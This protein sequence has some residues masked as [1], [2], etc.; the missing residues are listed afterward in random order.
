[1]FLNDSMKQK[2]IRELLR[3]SVGVASLCCLIA[4]PAFASEVTGSFGTGVSSGIEGTVHNCS[5]LSVTNGSVSA[6][7]SCSISCNSGY[8]LSG[9]SCNP[10]GGGGGGGGGGGVLPYTPIPAAPVTPPV[11][12]TP[13][14]TPA[15]T[16]TTLNG[17]QVLMQLGTVDQLLGAIGSQLN[18]T[19]FAKYKLLLQ[20]DAKEFGTPFSDAQLVNTSNF[21]T[22]GDSPA[23][24]KLGAGE[25]RAVVRDYL[26]TVGR[27]NI[28]WEDVERMVNG[29]KI[30]GRN[31]PK[32]QAQVT[33]VEANWLLMVGHAPN[34]KAP[35]EDLAWNTLMYR[36]RFPRDLVKEQAGIVKFKKIFK[37]T[38]ATPL[39]WAIVRAFG[40]A[41]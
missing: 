10:N 34:F 26:E 15:P 8:S 20:A 35:S 13:E 4:L 38:P 30:L 21:V 24:I 41:L 28:N 19:D 17:V 1:M 31:L 36:I 12:P 14:P 37:R 9:S 7:P 2:T 11:T 27:A 22:Y 6:Y 23:S 25:R 40:Y 16:P 18:P 39:E 32:E 33:R 5:I 3:A 29:H